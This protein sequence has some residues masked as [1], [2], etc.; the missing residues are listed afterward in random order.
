MLLQWLR[1]RRPLRRAQTLLLSWKMTWLLYDKSWTVR[2]LDVLSCLLW[3]AST[4][5]VLWRLRARDW[6]P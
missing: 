5:L 2:R 6:M 4:R 3:Q 1:L